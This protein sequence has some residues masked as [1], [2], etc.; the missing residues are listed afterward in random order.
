LVVVM[1][2]GSGWSQ[3]QSAT[4]ANTTDASAERR[5]MS[6]IVAWNN[7][8]NVMGVNIVVLRR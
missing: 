7:W 6:D 5:V 4:D 1:Q 8:V 3:A 2:P